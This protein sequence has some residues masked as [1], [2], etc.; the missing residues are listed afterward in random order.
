DEPEA[1]LPEYL[2]RI[3]GVAPDRLSRWRILRKSL[4]ARDRHALQFVY[5]AEVA[6]AEDEDRVLQQ[7]LRTSHPSVRLEFHE[8]APF[9]LPPPGA[10]PLRGR[11]VV[12]GSGPA[13]LF[14]ACILA[15]RGYAPLVL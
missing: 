1:S 15:E 10:E 6:L 14:A 3:F 13:G 9:E 12:V 5:S 2:A 8:D 7:A 4:D 11:P